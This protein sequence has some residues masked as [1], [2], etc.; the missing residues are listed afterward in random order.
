VPSVKSIKEAMLY[1]T[2]QER[3]FNGLIQKFANEKDAVIQRE[4]DEKIEKP[5][6]IFTRQSD[7]GQPRSRSVIQSQVQN[8]PGQF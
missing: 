8:S 2:E 4:I 6:S 1:V 7:S 3:R 5:K